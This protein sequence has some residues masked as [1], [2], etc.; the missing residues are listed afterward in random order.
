MKR[1]NAATLT[2]E[3]AQLD[4]ASCLM[5]KRGQLIFEF[6]KTGHKA[7]EI[8]RINSCTKSVLS[9]LLCIAMDQGHL[10]DLSTPMSAFF[11]VARG[12]DLHSITLLHLLT[13]TSG[14]N[15]TEFGGQNSFPRMTKSPHWV[16]FVLEQPLS[17][18]PGARMVYNSG[19]S[20]LLAA[21]LASAAGMSVASFAERYLFG[22]MG[23]E[24]YTW[25]RD[26]QGIHT[27]GFGLSLRPIDMLKFG[28]LYEQKGRWANQ[29]LITQELVTRST[30]PAIIAEAPRRGY[31]GW[32]W[33]A[34]AYPDPGEG[35]EAT[36]SFTYFNAYGF[37]GQA[38]YVIPSLEIVV[39]L[40]CEPRKKNQ[41][42]L[43]VFRR[44][45]APKL[46][47]GTMSFE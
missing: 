4:L 43:Q 36:Q 34:D 41:I 6:D 21:I 38:I 3:L 33:W 5:S 30:Q 31:Y 14:M 10:P 8:A 39:V 42:P 35:N 1:L 27:G 11:P 12:S 47:E 17:D 20:Q 44:F 16:N 23:I 2:S 37:G 18:P 32:H 46:A 25:E 19:G 9:A 22:P 24:E 26:P 40:T 45:I 29:Q 13:M 15:W 28:Q 7:A